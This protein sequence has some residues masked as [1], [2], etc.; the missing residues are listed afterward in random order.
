MGANVE[1][2]VM[3]GAALAGANVQGQEAT[4]VGENAI[5][6]EEALKLYGAQ[7]LIAECNRRVADCCPNYSK[8]TDLKAKM[9]RCENDANYR[10]AET[11]KSETFLNLKRSL[12]NGEFRADEAVVAA[13]WLRENYDVGYD[14]GIVEQNAKEA[15]V[16]D[17][18]I[19]AENAPNAIPVRGEM[20]GEIIAHVDANEA[21]KRFSIEMRGIQNHVDAD[22]TRAVI[23]TIDNDAT[24]SEEEKNQRKL[25]EARG[26]C[27]R[28]DETYSSDHSEKNRF[29]IKDNVLRYHPELAAQLGREGT[30]GKMHEDRANADNVEKIMGINPALGAKLVS[31]RVQEG[32]ENAGVDTSISANAP[33]MNNG[34]DGKQQS[35][36]LDP[37]MLAQVRANTGSS[38]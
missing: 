15:L 7:T 8:E 4:Q 9:E 1:I 25:E 3:A 32:A 22:V 19:V 23:K 13:N 24:L 5:S 37:V 20:T 26:Y 12:E 17:G 36:Q 6:W 14:W 38:R 27:N 34:V 2:V 11:I 30:S 33:K 28:V 16:L 18:K 10:L 29:Y 31:N 21:D 35:N